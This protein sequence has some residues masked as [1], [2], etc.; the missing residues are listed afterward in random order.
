MLYPDGFHVDSILK[1]RGATLL[2]KVRLVKAVVFPVV[3]YRCENWTIKKAERE[4]LMLLDCGV[5]ENS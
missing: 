5:G 3:T 1:A 2:T 4:E